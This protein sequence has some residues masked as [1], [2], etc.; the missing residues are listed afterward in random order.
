MFYVF[1]D[2]TFWSTFFNNENL[3]PETFHSSRPI[4]DVPELGRCAMRRAEIRISERLSVKFHALKGIHRLRLSRYNNNNTRLLY[5]EQRTR[6]LCEW[7]RVLKIRETR[8]KQSRVE[9]TPLCRIPC[10]DTRSSLNYWLMYEIA[11]SAAIINGRLRYTDALAENKSR[12]IRPTI[13]PLY[14]MK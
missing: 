9:D 1:G 5:T 8:L 3:K 10:T 2:N 7:A 6:N 13:T 12:D 4:R 11:G 14:N